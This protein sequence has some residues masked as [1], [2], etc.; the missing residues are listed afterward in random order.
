MNKCCLWSPELNHSI[1]HFKSKSLWNTFSL[2]SH[3]VLPLIVIPDKKS[4]TSFLSTY[5]LLY[6]RRFIKDRRFILSCCRYQMLILSSALVTFVVVLCVEIWR[7]AVFNRKSNFYYP[8]RRIYFNTYGVIIILFC[9]YCFYSLILY[10]IGYTT[11]FQTL[12]YFNTRQH[13]IL[14]IFLHNY[15]LELSVNQTHTNI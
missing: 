4:F 6:K 9:Y 14:S 15:I 12:I 10:W 11:N 8:L 1:C 7:I 3:L 2:S 13:Y 5:T